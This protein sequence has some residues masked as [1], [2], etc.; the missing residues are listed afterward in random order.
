MVWRWGLG[1]LAL[2]VLLLCWTRAG[3]LITLGEAVRVDVQVG[4]LRF[5]VVPGKKRRPKEK[6]P[7]KEEKD[8]SAGEKIISAAREKMF[9]NPGFAPGIIIGGNK[10]SIKNAIRLSPVSRASTAI[11]FALNSLKFILL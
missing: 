4:W 9:A 8:A 5:Q 3:V 6:K 2:L 10:L 1:V 7:P 11:F